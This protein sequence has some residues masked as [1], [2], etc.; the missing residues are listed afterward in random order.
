V[1]YLNIAFD[2]NIS[3]RC[4]EAFPSHLL[5]FHNGL[6]GSIGCRVGGGGVGRTMRRKCLCAVYRCVGLVDLFCEGNNL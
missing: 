2:F 1:K 5:Y 4:E 3:R 6:F